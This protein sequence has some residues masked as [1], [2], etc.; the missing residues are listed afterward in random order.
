[1]INSK[2]SNN[3]VNI[4][5]I[6]KEKQPYILMW[7]VSYVWIIIYLTWWTAS[8]LMESVF[9]HKL[10]VLIHTIG[11]LSAGVFVFIIRNKMFIKTSH[12]GSI[13]MVM[14]MLL[15]IVMGNTSF[16]SI[17][18]IVMGISLGLM[19]ISLLLPF[20]FNLNNTEKLYAV[21]GSNALI[22]IILLFQESGVGNLLQNKYIPLLSF[23]VIGIAHGNTSLLR[24]RKAPINVEDQITAYPQFN[25]RIYL[26]LVFNGVFAFLFKG[27]AKGILNIR[28]NGSNYHILMWYYLGGL[29][30][31]GIYTY[32]RLY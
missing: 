30:G 10:R 28:A 21:A 31:V 7:I 17:I 22:N 24:K 9:D 29:I 27:V 26:T 12:L 23:L 19:S 6:R 5:G 3:V 4:R 32:L 20:V 15:H 8:P 18:G 11:L 1:M 16:Q 25:S 2:L 13:L 14:G